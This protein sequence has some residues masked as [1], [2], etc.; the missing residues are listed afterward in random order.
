MNFVTLPCGKVVHKVYDYQFE[1]ESHTVHVAF[2]HFGE[3]ESTGADHSFASETRRSFARML[4]NH[5][6]CVQAG[7]LTRW[8]PLPDHEYLR[9]LA[10][11]GFAYES[12]TI[13][14]LPELLRTHI[15]IKAAH[16]GPYL[17]ASANPHFQHSYRH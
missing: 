7:Q 14:R 6:P 1:H 12:Y 15:S 16:E 8:F 17:L 10:A 5:Q 2:L 13:C 4:L 11:N 9:L 3:Y